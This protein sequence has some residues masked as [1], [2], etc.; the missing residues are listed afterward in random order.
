MNDELRAR[1]G[2]I[3]T[4][5]AGQVY[6]AASE[7]RGYSSEQPFIAQVDHAYKEAGYERL[8][9]K[10]A[11]ETLKQSL[12]DMQ[13]QLMTGQEFY[14]RFEMAISDDYKRNGV[15]LGV[16]EMLAYARDAAG[17]EPSND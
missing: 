13:K 16:A 5:F 12:E 4:D 8:H 11:Y 6:L 15:T 10:G 2:K 14:N 3:F 17:L 9:E 1:L 7:H